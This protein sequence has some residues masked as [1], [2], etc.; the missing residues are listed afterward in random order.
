VSVM[1][2]N[3]FYIAEGLWCGGLKNRLHRVKQLV[4]VRTVHVEK[5]VAPIHRHFIP[6]EFADLC[7]ADGS[8]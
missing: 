7:S 2:S 6:V 1:R 3:P 8:L 4:S 5:S